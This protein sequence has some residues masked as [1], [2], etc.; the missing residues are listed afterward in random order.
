METS[1]EKRVRNS[2][3]RQAIMG[4]VGASLTT[5]SKAKGSGLYS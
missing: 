3:A 4:N 5:Q 1:I 2:F